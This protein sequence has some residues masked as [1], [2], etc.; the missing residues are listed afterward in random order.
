[1]LESSEY[2]FVGGPDLVFVKVG[3]L[4]VTSP[5]PKTRYLKSTACKSEYLLAF[6]N[7]SNMASYYIFG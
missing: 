5:S 6:D 1:M 3:I 4:N 2:N 7:T